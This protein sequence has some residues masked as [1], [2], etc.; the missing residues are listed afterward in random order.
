MNKKEMKNMSY[1]D[2]SYKHGNFM[3]ASTTLSIC[4]LLVLMLLT[5]AFKSTV[6]SLMTARLFS[7]IISAFFFAAFAVLAVLSVKKEK[8]LWEYAVYSF[9]MSMGFLSLLGVPFFLPTTKFFEALFTTK[10]AQ[11]GLLAVNII[12]LI[13]TLTY[14]T[15]KS[16]PEK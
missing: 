8:G 16:K 10:N 13:A 3:L 12:Y 2:R 6:N 9:V 1:N 5:T 4:T 14:H 15:V 7:G 11:A